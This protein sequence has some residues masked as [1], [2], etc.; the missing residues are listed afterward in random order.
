MRRLVYPSSG[1]CKN[2]I[3]RNAYC[4]PKMSIIVRKN[5]SVCRWIPLKNGAEIPTEKSASMKPQACV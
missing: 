2:G 4:F 5:V 1:Y 3:V